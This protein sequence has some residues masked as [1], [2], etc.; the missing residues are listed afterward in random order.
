MRLD[1]ENYLTGHAGEEGSAA[2]YRHF[3][4]KLL[5]KSIAKLPVP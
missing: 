4:M 2:D 3:G 5:A 1:V